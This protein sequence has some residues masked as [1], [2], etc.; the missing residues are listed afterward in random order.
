MLNLELAK[1]FVWLLRADIRESL[2]KFEDPESE[3]EKWW[4]SAGRADYPFWGA[5][6]LKEKEQLLEPVGIVKVGKLEQSIPKAM[7]MVLSRRPDVVQKYTQNKTLNIQAVSGWFWVIGVK[8][9]AMVSMVDLQTIKDL[10]RPVMV[11][12]AEDPTPKM[13]VPSPTILMSL[14]WHLLDHNIQEGMNLQL[15]EQRYRYFCWFFVWLTNIFKFQDL[16]SNRWKS[17]LQQEVPISEGNPE[18]GELPRFALM[19]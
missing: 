1:K 12:P 17:W 15:S 4:L 2:L 14:A 8:E 9:H 10:D 5:L 13:D 16:I 11:N 19:E 7:Q 3:F 6:S 18:L